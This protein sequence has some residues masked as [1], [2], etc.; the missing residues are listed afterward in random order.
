MVAVN[1]GRGVQVLGSI[2]RTYKGS[3]TNVASTLVILT[4]WLI[5]PI[6]DIL[7]LSIQGRTDAQTILICFNG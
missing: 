7:V 3:L 2:I 4:Q 1:D 6:K 5:L